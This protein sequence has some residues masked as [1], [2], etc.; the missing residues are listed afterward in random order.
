[1]KQPVP[2]PSREAVTNEH[3]RALISVLHELEAFAVE[4][5][6][7]EIT[8]SKAPEL[9]GGVATAIGVSLTNVL[10]RID[11]VI[12]DNARWC[13]KGHAKLE[14]LLARLYSA[15]IELLE[16]SK[17][18]TLDARSPAVMFRP[19]IVRQDDGQIVAFYGEPDRPENWIVGLGN[20]PEEA[21]ADF[22][23][24]FK[25]TAK[26]LN[27]ALDETPSA[28]TTPS[29]NRKGKKHNP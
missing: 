23:K 4:P 26:G 20:T 25:A 1:M 28:D 10:H 3:L 22:N 21:M 9:D 6:R 2:I 18:T 24:Q 15:N 29:R 17:Q 5:L 11:Q 12:Q 19:E 8:G 13:M 7:D 16:V 14:R 27:R